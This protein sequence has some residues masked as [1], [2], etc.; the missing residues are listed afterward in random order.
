MSMHVPPTGVWVGRLVWPCQ[1][2]KNQINFDLINQQIDN[3]ILFEDLWFVGD[4][5]MHIPL[6]EVSH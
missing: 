4:I 2:T 1:M 5:S 6:T 3:S